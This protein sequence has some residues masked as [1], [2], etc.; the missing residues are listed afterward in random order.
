M[1][2]AAIEKACGGPQWAV[3]GFGSVW[4]LDDNAERPQGDLG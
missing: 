2:C 1:I 4:R 3:M